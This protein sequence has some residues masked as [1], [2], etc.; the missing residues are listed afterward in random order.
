MK[1]GANV[2]LTGEPGSGKTYVLR[3]YIKY[4]KERGIHVAVTASTGIAATH[5]NGTTLHSWSGIGIKEDLRLYDLDKL[6]G[7]QKLSKRIRGAKILIIDE[8]SML[9]AGALTCV[10][11]LCREVFQSE[12]PFGGMQ[13]IFAGDYYQLPPVSRGSQGANFAYKSPAWEMSNPLCCYLTE[14]YRQEDESFLNILNAI[15]S[16]SFG[17]EHWEIISERLARPTDIP[18]DSPKLFTHNADVDLIN[19]QRLMRL[20]GDIVH[21]VMAEQGRESRVEALKRGCLS[22]ER[23][24]LKEGA[25]VMFTK[26]DP[27][28]RFV[29]GS[30]GTVTGFDKKNRQPIVTLKTGEVIEVTPMEWMAEVDDKIAAR[31]VQIPLRLAWAITVH[32]SQGMSLDSAVV[33]LSKVFEYGQGYVALSRIRSLKGLFLLG[34]NALSSKVHPEIMEMDDSFR[35]ASLE[36]E[37]IFSKMQRMELSLIQQNFAVACGAES[38]NKESYGGVREKHPNAYRRW[39]QDQDNELQKL[40]RDGLEVRELAEKLGRKQ[41]A[42]RSRLARMGLD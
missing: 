24:S 11:A 42:I 28:M 33:D 25:V 26:N 34:W 6:A 41:G 39:S 36:A 17:E 7:S 31:I 40:Y 1:T 10:E 16:D 8:V 2:F 4:A 18:E 29:N 32:K 9:A 37:K 19:E 27:K 13:V 22:P 5:L 35:G 23:L 30:I 12:Q 38:A 20:P 15:R 14:Q 21:Y 3:E